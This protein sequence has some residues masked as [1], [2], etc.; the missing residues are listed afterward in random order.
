MWCLS[1]VPAITV[2][3]LLTIQVGSSPCALNANVRGHSRPYLS[4]RA[5]QAWTQFQGNAGVWV[6]LPLHAVHANVCPT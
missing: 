2:S 3:G 4:S 1:N 5:M 6:I